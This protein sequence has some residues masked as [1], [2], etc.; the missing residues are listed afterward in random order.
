MGPEQRSTPES[1]LQALA[2]GEAST[3]ETLTQMQIDA[4]ERSGLD[5]ETYALV[6]LAA[7]VATDAAPVAYLA[8]LGAAG[9]PGISTDKMLG[10]FVAIAPIVG[11]AR[12]LSAASGMG[13]AGLIATAVRRSMTGST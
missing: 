1:S 10:T 7:L 12:V 5:E 9:N 13:R 4:R 8:H 6:R 2:A 11:S 3:L